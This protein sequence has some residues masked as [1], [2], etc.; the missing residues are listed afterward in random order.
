MSRTASPA[1]PR[2]LVL[3]A[4]LAVGAL[5]GTLLTSAASAD[6][7]RGDAARAQQYATKVATSAA[8][9][10]RPAAGR[11]RALNVRAKLPA[12]WRK[13][14]I[15]GRVAERSVSVKVRGTNR[16][17]HWNGGKAVLWTR[18]CGA[19]R[20]VAARMAHRVDHHKT[21][22]AG[23]QALL[24]IRAAMPATWRQA[25][26][27]SAVRKGKVT[28]TVKPFKRCLTWNTK[29]VA[30]ITK[31]ACS[32]PKPNPKPS[33]S[34]V[35]T[36]APLLGVYDGGPKGDASTRSVFGRYGDISSSYYQPN[37]ASLNVA[38][39][40]ARIDRGTAPVLTL[41]SKGTQYINDIAN[42]SG[43]GWSWIKTYVDSLDTLGS[44]GKARKVPVFATLDHEWEVKVNQG[45]LSGNSARAAVYARALSNF[46][47]L[48]DQAAP[49]VVTLYWYGHFD[50]ADI[51]AVGSALTVAPDMFALDPYSGQ[52]AAAN[53]TI[54]QMVQ[55]KLTWLKN[56]S[57]YKG[58]RIGLAEF[59][60][61]KSDTN[62]ATYF[63]K[64]MRGNL[65]NL[66]LAFGIFFNRDDRPYVVKI[67]PNYPRSIAAVRNSLAG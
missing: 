6:S 41:T 8:S 57:W 25:I 48:V 43:A 13:A 38:A 12:A 23:R 49:E 42:K 33:G 14:T 4:V 34:G 18:L 7:S 61:D 64:N 20:G 26:K 2:P 3:L 1:R 60:A 10:A 56:R 19:R 28:L 39:E 59:G 54:A 50:T 29:G 27:V 51:N 31:G 47:Q 15:V 24:N 21:A 17:V 9:K 44:Y 63:F 67:N 52:H 66:D 40:K 62:M 36:G 46:F 53:E 55:P 32:F 5:V 58:Q 37:Q 30:K 22:R 16:C 11:Q 65:K 45:M 35:P